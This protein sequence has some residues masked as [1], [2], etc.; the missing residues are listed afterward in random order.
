MSAYAAISNAIPRRVLAAFAVAGTVASAA[1][2]EAIPER[3]MTLNMC[4]DQLVLDL[5]PPERITSVTYISHWSSDPDLAAKAARVGTNYGNAEEV[6]AQAPDLVIAGVLSTPATRTLLKDVGYPLYELSS[7]DTFDEIREQ[8][9]AVANLLGVAERGEALI[10]EMDATLAALDRNRPAEP[11]TVVAWNGGGTAPGKGTLFDEI[12]RR[13]G[14]I[15]L[16]TR[17]SDGYMVSFGMEELL[18]ARPDLIAHGEA[19]LETPSL[20]HAPLMHPVIRALYDARRITYRDTQYLCGTPRS[21]EAARALQSQMKAAM[22][23][24][25]AR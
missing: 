20:T 13:A 16:A 22:T 10:A 3:V 21:A 23:R 1:A 9:R 18:A 19:D 25:G 4:A 14:G 24:I 12:L 5:L 8:T 11:I 2:A 6:F 7:A 15:N 17:Y